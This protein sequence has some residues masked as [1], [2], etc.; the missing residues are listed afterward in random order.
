[1]FDVLYLA[2]KYLAYH[3]FKTGVLVASITLIVYLPIGL[4]VLVNQSAKQLTARAEATPLLVGAKGSPL[5][6][7]LRSLYFEADIPAD[8]RFA[9]VTRIEQSGLA[10]AIPLHLRFRT[11]SNTIVGTSLEYFEFRQLQVDRGRLFGF[12]GECVLGAQA[13]RRAGVGL[14]ESVMSA[15]QSVFDIA[16]VYPLKMKVV[17]VLQ[18][19]GTPDD[20][21]VFVDTRTAWVIAGLAHGHQDLSKP[22]AQ[23]GVLRRQDEKIIANASVMQYNEITPENAAS[24]HFHG[25][26]ETFPVT[27]VIAVPHDEK[28]G[29]VLQ[30]RYLGDEELVQIVQPPVVMHDLLQTILTVRR[31]ILLGI[32]VVATATLASMA[33]VF[34][35]SW[36]LRRRE[37]ETIVKI[38]GSRG[39]ILSLLAAEVLSVIAAGALLATFLTL[40][41]VWLAGSA[42]HLLVQLT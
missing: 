20:R 16:G 29:T 24:F 28:S 4:N 18:P 42:T 13:A 26:P 6:L 2:W 34:M 32:G 39:R 15:P 12:L 21:A 22:E 41:T 31:Y 8:M 10:R 30:G 17:G 11:G 19:N 23:S 3:R 27:A 35:L 36:Q 9:E 14:G 7:V 1:M 38:G 5:E 40:A 33:L 37:V 25:D